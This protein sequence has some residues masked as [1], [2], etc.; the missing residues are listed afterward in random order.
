M[1][2]KIVL[3]NLFEFEVDARDQ[4]ATEWRGLP[5]FNQ[6]SNGPH[7]QIIISFKTP[8]DVK[9]F[10]KLTGLSITDKTKSAWF[11]YREMNK[12]AE[13]FYYD[14]NDNIHPDADLFESTDEDQDEE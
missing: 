7:R 14:C 2:D 1:T 13:L 12:V 6:P 3:N 4:K 11:P 10:A 8:E 9:D 5:A